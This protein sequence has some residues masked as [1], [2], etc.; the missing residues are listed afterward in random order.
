MTPDEAI[1]IV[2]SK[3]R[4]RTRY[5][6][7]E[8]FLDEVLVGEIERLTRDLEGVSVSVCDRCGKKVFTIQN[9]VV[10]QCGWGGE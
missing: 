7:Q 5:E 1:S 4:C 10:C 3:A 9:N 2:K 8:P 6:G